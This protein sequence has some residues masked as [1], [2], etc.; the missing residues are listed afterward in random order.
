MSAA[1]ER[2]DTLTIITK[3][4]TAR[5]DPDAVLDA[6]L[7]RVVAATGAKRA[8][9]AL[10]DRH[11]GELVPERVAGDG[12]TEEKRHKRLRVTP[13]AAEGITGH[14]ARTGRPHRTGNVAEDPH[15]Y[16]LFD[17]VRSELAVPLLRS[18]ERVIGVL[19]LES[20]RAD[21]FTESHERL[22]VALAALGALGVSMAEHH[23]REHALI[24]IGRELAASAD[25]EALF[26]RI[27]DTAAGILRAG[28]AS[29]FLMEPDGDR[30]ILVA[31][32][33]PLRGLVRQATY[34]VG[35]G[36][37]GWVAQSGEPL[38]VA[39]ASE[40]PRWR[41]KHEEFPEHATAGFLAVPVRSEDALEGVLR[42]VRDKTANSLPNPFDQ[43]DEDVL[44]T[45]ASQVA[46][47]VQRDRLQQRLMDSERMRAW[48]E[49]SARTAHMIGNKVFVMKGNLQELKRHLA[50]CDEAREAF[51]ASLG[52]L[53]KSANEVEG[54][55]QELKDFLVAPRLQR[56]VVDVN[57]LVETT[58]REALPAAAGLELE[59]D[60]APDL[61]RLEADAPRLA[62]CI[63]ELVENSV[64]WQPQG[65]RLRV[66]THLIE[67]SAAF[68]L[69]GVPAG[70]QYV[71]VDFADGGPG[72]PAELKE[73]IFRPFVSTR[74]RGMGLGLAIVREVLRAHGG[75]IVEVGEDGGADFVLLLPDGR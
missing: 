74:G 55:V 19:N 73:S 66:T 6:V 67:G 34:A 48:G 30:L 2:H 4:V 33:G 65:G 21:A 24:H 62:R 8:V 71:R 5:A 10:V 44:A 17:D 56:T 14:V 25:V 43:D 61:P 27:V 41:G 52:L 15:Y 51:G 23:R 37:T 53:E 32:R 13:S 9:V 42:V 58:V 47:A 20:D 16:P 1:D 3:L 70:R 38:R 29:L 26:E 57:E 63:E 12:W 54:L 49:M 59:F 46:I 18:G 68:A 36:L 64:A 72:V 35:E 31:S 40:D 45:L 75:D 11:N 39:E 28:D 7:A 50:D 22:A 60:L 69:A